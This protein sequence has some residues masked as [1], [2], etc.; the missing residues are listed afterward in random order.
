MSNSSSIYLS[1]LN[2]GLLLSL[3]LIPISLLA[4][5][6]NVNSIAII[7][8]GCLTAL[9]IAL[10]AK[11]KVDKKRHMLLWAILLY[12]LV[13]LFFVL[14]AT[15]LVDGLKIIRKKLPLLILP[16]VIYLNRNTISY[17]ITLFYKVFITAVVAASV[18]CFIQIIGDWQISE[19][20]LKELITYYKFTS[21]YL[22]DKLDIHPSYLSNFILL[23]IIFAHQLL[24]N[25]A[26]RITKILLISSWIYLSFMIIQLASRI[27]IL[28][29]FFLLIFFVFTTFNKKS[30]G[31][32]I[33]Q[34]F[35]IL[36]VLGVVFFL[37]TS[38]F[39]KERFDQGYDMYFNQG[40]NYPQFYEN[41][42]IHI[43][44]HFSSEFKKAPILGSGT[45]NENSNLYQNFVEDN[46]ERGKKRKLNYH[47]QYFQELTRSGIVGFLLF[48]GILVLFFKQGI[49]D[50]NSAF[51]L[52]LVFNCIFLFF[53]SALERHRGIVFFFFFASLFYF[54]HTKEAVNSTIKNNGK[55]QP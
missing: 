20:T 21:S 49:L 43:W 48:L 3:L 53:E 18:Y 5:K 24:E 15:E 50:K 12:F 55:E 35:K 37:L 44:K 19:K 29:Y 1:W 36:I 41:S 7:V 28:N 51:L 30:K 16:F 47:N 34:I 45:G 6:F 40:Q 32:R 27:Q 4:K 39:V 10:G 42:R 17:N 31:R 9:S 26:S 22:S 54:C 46:Y 38:K 33:F 25:S 52:F 8:S 2:K 11:I 14:K 13:L 23:A